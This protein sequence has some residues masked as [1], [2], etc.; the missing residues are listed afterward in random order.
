MMGLSK[1]INVVSEAVIVLGLTKVKSVAIGTASMSQFSQLP[2][3]SYFNPHSMWMHSMATAIFMRSI[4]QA[5]PRN[6]RPNEDQI[7]LAGLLHD[8]GFMVL[9][10]LDQAV[11]DALHL[12]MHLQP[13]RPI[14][15]VELET[16]G[17]TH[18]QIGMQLARNWNLSPEIVE[19]IGNH[20]PS[21]ADKSSADN[22]L[23]RILCL[24][25]KL[26]PDFGIAEHTASTLSEEDWLDLGIQIS[27]ADEVINLVNELAMQVA[28]Q[29]DVL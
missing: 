13:E 16:L 19:V 1:K 21:L 7:F 27:D 11:S 6:M 10:H 9:H 5:M 28:Q 17:I 24:A 26:A 8:I 25:E 18:C 20:H 12:Q 2:S 15:E 14:L 29:N 22:P 3:S 4:A 23:I